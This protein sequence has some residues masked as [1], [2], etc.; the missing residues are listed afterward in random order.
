MKNKSKLFVCCKELLSNSFTL[1]H[2]SVEQTRVGLIMHPTDT[3]DGVGYWKST[4]L[5]TPADLDGRDSY[6]IYD[7]LLMCGLYQDDL[8]GTF[9]FENNDCS[10]MKAVT[11]EIC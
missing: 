10:E 8:I 7:A 4:G 3:T 1:F 6:I 2:S 5:I 9:V 11:C